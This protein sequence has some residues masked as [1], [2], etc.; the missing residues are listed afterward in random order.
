MMAYS[1]IC[2]ESTNGYGEIWQTASVNALDKFSKL[3]FQVM[4]WQLRLHLL[5]TDTSFKPNNK[6]ACLWLGQ[7]IF[8]RWTV[9]NLKTIKSSLSDRTFL[10]N[11]N[12]ARA[13]LH[14]P[15]IYFSIHVIP[16]QYRTIAGVST[17]YVTFDNIFHALHISKSNVYRS[18]SISNIKCTT[19]YTQLHG[20]V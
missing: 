19:S 15:A 1:K 2:V 12:I 5:F 16:C 7:I 17:G 6:R 13:M 11:Y 10:L 20:S 18:R 4:W 3:I 14:S 8:Y 9:I